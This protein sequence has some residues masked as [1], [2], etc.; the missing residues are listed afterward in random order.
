MTRRCPRCGSTDVRPSKFTFPDV[1]VREL[2]CL[3]CGL[4]EDRRADAPDYVAWLRRWKQLDGT[5]AKD[6]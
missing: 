3:H 2:G 4:I 6:R 1:V 5:P